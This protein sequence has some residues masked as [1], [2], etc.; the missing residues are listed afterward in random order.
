MRFSLDTRPNPVTPTARSRNHRT[1]L[2]SKKQTSNL[3][4]IRGYHNR[5]L[6]L[7]SALL[8]RFH[9]FQNHEFTRT[10]KGLWGGGGG[11]R[12]MKR[13][14]SVIHYFKDTW[15]WQRWSKSRQFHRRCRVGGE[16]GGG[17]AIPFP[18]P[19][20]SWPCRHPFHRSR[21]WQSSPSSTI[22]RFPLDLTAR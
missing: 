10:E 16:G 8:A 4:S 14:R 18:T 21:R 2:I 7:H 3:H 12:N 9:Y 19:P 6:C 1:V 15:Q 22:W 20:P 11:R 17:E 5:N 13:I